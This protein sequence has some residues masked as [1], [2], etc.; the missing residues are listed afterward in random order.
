[1]SVDLA[2]L[3]ADEEAVR[4]LANSAHLV[5]MSR[6]IQNVLDGLNWFRCQAKFAEQELA[7]TNAE[8]IEVLNGSH[9]NRI[10]GGDRS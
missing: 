1:M 7:S 10:F 5:A 3:P 6:N 2:K 8:L 4:G 9:H